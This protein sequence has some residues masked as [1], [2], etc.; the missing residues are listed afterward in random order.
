MTPPSADRVP[1]AARV[2]EG[3]GVQRRA[4]PHSRRSRAP[5]MVELRAGLRARSRVAERSSIMVSRPGL[6]G[7]ACMRR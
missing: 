7:A 3:T 2:S 4:S 5:H 6:N 1:P